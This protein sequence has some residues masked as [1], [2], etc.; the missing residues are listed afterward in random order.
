MSITNIRFTDIDFLLTKNDLTND[1]NVKY[2]GNAIS[3]SIKNIILTT[4]KE[5]LFSQS[6]GG[7]AYDLVFNSPSPLDLANKR[8]FFV[9]AIK[10]NEPRVNV[11]S[12]NIVDSGEGSWIISVLYNQNNSN[13]LSQNVTVII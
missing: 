4:Q 9:A 2:D 7:N 6:F 8:A 11:Q 1:V 5:K 10:N 3:Q 12:I 13:N